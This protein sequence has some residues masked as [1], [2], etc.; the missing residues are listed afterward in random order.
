MTDK[1]RSQILDAVFANDERDRRPLVAL[2]LASLP[3]VSTI[4]AHI[5]ALDPFLGGVLQEALD[6]Q[7]TCAHSTLLSSLRELHVLSEVPSCVMDNRKPRDEDNL[8]PSLQLH[9]IWPVLY[10]KGLSKL[11][12]YNLNPDGLGSLLQE[13]LQSEKKC[14]DNGKT[15]QCYIQHL[16]IATKVKSP[17]RAEDVTALL[18]LPLALRSLSFSW[19]DDKAKKRING[20]NRKIWQI[21]CNE[22]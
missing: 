15:N 12:L 10:L 7:Q 11:R 5:P 17:C 19:D 2:L 18:T 6:Q 8:E 9:D 13:T 22:V 14:P 21:S 3:R 4:Y 1:L 20:K 16:H